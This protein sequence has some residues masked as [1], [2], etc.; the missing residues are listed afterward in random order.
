VAGTTQTQA[1]A[2]ALT[3]EINVVATVGTTSDGVK[4]PSAEAGLTCTVINN[5]ANTLNLY[6]AVGDDLGAGI[7]TS[8]NVSAGTNVTYTAYD[9]TNWESV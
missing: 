6:P 3:G 5:G 7:D 1:G 2:T 9:S 4:L 8:V